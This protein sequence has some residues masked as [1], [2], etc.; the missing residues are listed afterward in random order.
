MS[1]LIIILIGL[2]KELLLFSI[3]IYLIIFYLS[4]KDKLHN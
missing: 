4:T 2:I 1:G 3:L